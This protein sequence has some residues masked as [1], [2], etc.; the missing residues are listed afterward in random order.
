VT[1]YLAAA[2]AAALTTAVA[3]PA[4]AS[5]HAPAAAAKGP[6]ESVIGWGQNQFGVLGDG[7]TTNTSTPVFARL[8]SR[9][10]Y[11]TVRSVET[12]VALTTT[13]RVYAWGD[14]DFGQVGDGTTTMRPR[15]VVASKLH[16]VK[17]TALRESGH[18]TLALT[19]TGKV[20]AWGENLGGEL[21]DG[22]TKNRRIPVRV[23]IPAGVHV[24]AI[25]AGY[26]SGL[27]LTRSGR[28]LAWGGNAAGQVGDGTAKDRHA[29][30]YV[31]LPSHTKITSIAAGYGTGYAV[32]SAGRLLAW[33]YN[34]MG[35]LG[36]GTTASRHTPVRVKLPVG[37]KVTAA[38][39]GLAHALALTTGGRVLACGY[40]F[41]GQLGDGSTTD[42]HEP[43]FVAL[44][45]GT[46]VRAMAA[47][48]D[49]SAVLTSG[50]HIL[51]WGRN[52]LGQ[53]GDG[54]TT[55]S[56]TPVRVHLP[57]GFAPTAIGSGWGS[58][59]VLAI[60]HRAGS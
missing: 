36:D 20:L 46:K 18:W 28:V 57:P 29:P 12:S 37:V 56:S 10:R 35:G 38:T 26:N 41:Y 13:G 47:G 60:G 6:G 4:T 34:G 16:G 50:G 2:L 39:A 43:V 48:N 52:D 9:F 58:R 51:T 49:F 31:R 33:G 22:T 11:T 30:V 14:N 54:T 42:R 53:L 45:T 7:T 55:D 24:T 1:R 27:A 44:P 17:V 21:G 59:T 15:P 19:S 23:K 32:T 8:P 25:S 5:A 40:N 3:A